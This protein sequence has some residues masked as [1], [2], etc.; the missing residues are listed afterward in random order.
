MRLLFTD[1]T[2]VERLKVDIVLT[3]QLL[4]LANTFQQR[5]LGKPA[6]SPVRYLCSLYTL[7]PGFNAVCARILAITLHFALLAKNTR[8][9]TRRPQ[10]LGW[11]H[12]GRVYGSP[13][14]RGQNLRHRSLSHNLDH[15]LYPAELGRE[16]HQVVLLEKGR[17]G[18][19]DSTLG[20]HWHLRLLAQAFIPFD[21]DTNIALPWTLTSNFRFKTMCALL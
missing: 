17:E 16:R 9:H 3:E 18:M 10:R 12:L 7:C 19:S 13:L 4:V 8:K 14:C 1:W 15:W 6:F 2:S 20:N 11:R 21:L 5:S